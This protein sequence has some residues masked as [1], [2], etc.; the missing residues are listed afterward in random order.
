MIDTIMRVSHHIDRYRWDLIVHPFCNVALRPLR[1]PS[2]IMRKHSK[3]Q[4]RVGSLVIH[5]R[6]AITGSDLDVIPALFKHHTFS[7]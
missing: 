7:L 4:E 3:Q 1:R 2:Q 5:K 6:R